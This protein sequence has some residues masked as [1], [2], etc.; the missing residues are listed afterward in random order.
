MP[1]RARNVFGT[2]VALER[3]D[4]I[5]FEKRL[6]AQYTHSKWRKW[7]TRRHALAKRVMEK[8][9]L[10]NRVFLGKCAGRSE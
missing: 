8:V 5:L 2:E 1:S 4:K 7:V 9:G 10:K 3:L 6:N